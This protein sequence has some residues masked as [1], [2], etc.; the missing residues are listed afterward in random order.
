MSE[1][2]EMSGVVSNM[3]HQIDNLLK[4][5]GDLLDHAK[6]MKDDHAREIN[7]S[8]GG[9]KKKRRKLKESRRALSDYK[10][11]TAAD[12]DDRITHMKDHIKQC[13]DTIQE[14]LTLRMFLR[15]SIEWIKTSTSES[16]PR[17]NSMLYTL[18][19]S[20]FGMFI[21]KAFID[22]E[23]ESRGEP[24]QG[25]ETFWIPYIVWFVCGLFGWIFDRYVSRHNSIGGKLE[26]VQN[27]TY[28]TIPYQ[29][30]RDALNG[31]P[32]SV[33]R[34]LT[35]PDGGDVQHRLGVER[36]GEELEHSV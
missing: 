25:P 13:E 32:D 14:L 24:H 28:G 2:Y 12:Y 26:S 36:N 4:R 18:T 20:N 34:L 7:G 15:A 30:M 3:Q 23:R 11:Q 21:S 16:F 31:N 33:R 10:I 19:F 9:L 6:L 5:N 8:R 22:F 1:S 35:R 29:T 27:A 17:Y